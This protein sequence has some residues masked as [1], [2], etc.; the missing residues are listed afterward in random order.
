VLDLSLDPADGAGMSWLHR[1]TE[2]L[3]KAMGEDGRVAITV[4]ADRSKAEAVRAKF[5]DQIALGPAA[6][7]P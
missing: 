6:I 1:H 7:A 2:V 3:G 5:G 4:R